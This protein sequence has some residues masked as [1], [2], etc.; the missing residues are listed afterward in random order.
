MISKASL[1]AL[2]LL[3][4]CGIN[5]P[6]ELSLETIIQG[7]GVYYCE[8][9]LNNCE[10]RIV[11][12]KGK[13]LITL[14]SKIEIEGKKRY[15]LAHEIGHYKMHRED[16]PVI[17]DSEENFVDYLKGG[18]H[19][20]EANEFASEFLMPREIFYK[21]CKGKRISPELIKSLSSR[22]QTSLTSTILKFVNFGNHEVCVV[23]CKNNK[24]KWWKKSKDFY[25]FLNFVPN[26]PSPADSVANELFNKK[27]YYSDKD[28]KQQ[29]WKS[30]WFDLKEDEADV[31]FFEFCLYVPSYSYSI[32]LI[33]EEN[34]RV[35]MR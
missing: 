22:F 15:A 1:H 28:L 9:P 31:P 7:L 32:S 27:T 23:Y 8:K 3:D 4:N 24:M 30:T 2:Q 14:N 5:D 18:P 12:Y 26:N 29:I 21:E 10:G 13:T 6:T 17:S 33:W 35:F 25:H 11:S 19:E 16:I 20:H 34:K